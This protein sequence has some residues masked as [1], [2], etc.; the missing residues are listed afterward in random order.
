[1]NMFICTNLRFK[2]EAEEVKAILQAAKVITNDETGVCI[3]GTNSYHWV[4][5]C[6]DGQ[7]SL[8]A[9]SASAAQTSL[10][11]DR[12]NSPSS[13]SMRAASI[14]SVVFM[15][16]LTGRDDLVADGKGGQRDDEPQGRLLGQRRHQ[17][18]IRFI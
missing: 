11:P 18:A 13:M 12:R 16:F 8:S 15:P 9:V 1:M 2:T 17:N 6:K 14:L 10:T 4:L 3:E 5:H 7:P